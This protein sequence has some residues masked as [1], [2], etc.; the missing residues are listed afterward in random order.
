[1]RYRKHGKNYVLWSLPR[2]GWVG[3]NLALSVAMMNRGYIRRRNR[4][5]A[6]T[7]TYRSRLDRHR[8]IAETERAHAYDNFRRIKPS[9]SRGFF[10]DSS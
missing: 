2:R 10:L 4:P 6:L 8:H 1:M 7:A 3:V 5:N 9:Q